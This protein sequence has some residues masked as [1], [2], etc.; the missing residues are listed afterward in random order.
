MEQQSP[1]PPSRRNWSGIAA[2]LV[3]CVLIIV[4]ALF[5]LPNLFPLGGL[6][7]ES[8]STYYVN[9]VGNPANTDS[10]VEITYPSDYAQ[11]ANYSLSIINQNRTIFGL[12]PVTLSPIP[13][14]Q[15]HADSM[16]QN[17]YFSHWDTQG[18]KPYMRYSLLNG[19]GF[20]EE[21]VAYEYSTLPTFTSMQKVDKV[22]NDLEWQMMNNDTICCNNGH[23]DNILN[24]YHNRVSIGVAYDSTHVYFVEDFETHLVNFKTPIVQ[25]NS[26]SL[27]GNTSQSLN[28]SSIEVFYDSPPTQLTPT[29][30]DEDYSMPYGQGTFVGGVVAPCNG[31]FQRCFQFSQGATVR[32]STWDVNRTSVNIQF[33]LSDFTQ[34]NGNGVYTIYLVQG[35]QTNPEYLTSISVFVS[36]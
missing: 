34:S 15:Q 26:V 20:V 25:G 12:A 18:F 16:L 24:P 9:H 4:I 11:I 33:S 31:I 2:A 32:A 29:Q 27:I 14:G 35:A 3:A 13:S 22:I 17:A 23:R 1:P 5:S 30:L 28:P 36:G 6:T 10:S 19:T 21:N 7:A 8:T